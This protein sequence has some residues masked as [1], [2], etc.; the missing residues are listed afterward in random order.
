[1]SETQPAEFKLKADLLMPLTVR[2]DRPAALRIV[3]HLAAIAL[4]AAA[5]T[6]SRG[7]LWIIPLMVLLSYLVAF[8]FNAE[9]E[10]AHQTAFRRR[11]L[12]QLV[13]HLSGFAVLLPYEYYRLF[14]WDH[15]RFTHDP[16]RD[17]ELSVPIPR[18]R[19]GQLLLWT[20]LLSWRTRIP[21][22]F[23]HASGR[24][25]VPWVAAE[26]RDGIV[27]EAR[28]Y[29]AGYALIA[30]VS[31]LTQSLLALELW[32]IPVVLGQ[33]FLRPYLLAEHTGCP[34]TRLML[35][36]TRTTYTNALVR[37]FAWNM[38]YHT[39]HHA[40]PAVPFHALPALNHHLASYLK[41]VEP[42]YRASSRTVLRYL[43]RERQSARSRHK[44]TA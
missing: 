40:Y 24:V 19:I 20:G 5:V 23:R 11:I 27:F 26:K 29:L 34:H 37:F 32:L 33:I 18:T 10:T 43:G 42:S 31:I 14:H 38:P 30:L 36:N 15:H 28:C 7:T 22:I 35:E 25:T 39:A 17:P 2:R 4:A 1:M 21:I 9:H 12:N 41:S 8:L 13:G 44:A 3:L 16:L 6:L